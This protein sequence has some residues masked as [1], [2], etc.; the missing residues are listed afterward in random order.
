MFW[1]FTVGIYNGVCAAECDTG[2]WF[3]LRSLHSPRRPSPSSPAST[4]G[5]N[6]LTH[7]HATGFPRRPCRG[8]LLGRP[9]P[10]FPAS[11]P[12]LVSHESVMLHVS[13]TR[14]SLVNRNV[15]Y[16]FFHPLR[17]GGRASRWG[18]VWKSSFLRDVRAVGIT[19]RRARES[20][21]IRNIIWHQKE[22]P[23]IF[24]VSGIARYKNSDAV[25]LISYR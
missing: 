19:G 5:P 6:E 8:S 15:D 17:K 12:W 7:N 11:R 18:V 16:F 10:R 25:G 24:K 22:D 13:N 14:Q 23:C 1:I 2:V 9:L 3:C 20:S 4:A 21:W